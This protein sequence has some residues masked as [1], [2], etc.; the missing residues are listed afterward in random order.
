MFWKKNNQTQPLG[1]SSD[2]GGGG[3][4]LL[5]QWTRLSA[6]LISSAESRWSAQ[7]VQMWCCW[8]SDSASLN[9]YRALAGFTVGSL[10]SSYLS[11]FP[12]P[13]QGDRFALEQARSFIVWVVFLT[14]PSL[15]YLTYF[16]SF[17]KVLELSWSKLIWNKNVFYF[18]SLVYE[19]YF[20]LRNH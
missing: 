8:C 16:I 7:L 9:A 4:V 5:T 12:E 17:L 11:T 3:R 18:G 6:V 15:L 20:N 14:K 1:G 10:G 19:L 2:K 13:L